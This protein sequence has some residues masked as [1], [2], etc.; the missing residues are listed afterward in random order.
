[1]TPWM[2]MLLRLLA[3]ILLLLCLPAPTHAIACVDPSP[4]THGS[5]IH[6]A[7]LVYVDGHPH[8]V[9]PAGIDPVD[10]PATTESGYGTSF[11]QPYMLGI[12]LFVRK[13]RAANPMPLPNG[14]STSFNFVYINMANAPVYGDPALTP[15]ITQFDFSLDK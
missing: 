8:G 11:S 2:M 12:D 6:V 1:M 5:V 3:A 10:T 14:Q 4:L 13:M 9:L 15:N 7:L